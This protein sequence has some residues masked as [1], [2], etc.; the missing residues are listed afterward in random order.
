[1]TQMSITK[2]DQAMDVAKRLGFLPGYPRDYEARY[3]IG[4]FIDKICNTAEEV[5]ALYEELRSARYERWYGL[6]MIQ[7]AHDSICPPVAVK[8]PD[9]P[10]CGNSGFVYSETKL[11]DCPKCGNTGWFTMQSAEETRPPGGNPDFAPPSF[12]DYRCECGRNSDGSS[13]SGYKPCTCRHRSSNVNLP[14]QRLGSTAANVNKSAVRGQN[15]DNM[16]TSLFP[17][18]NLK[19]KSLPLTRSAAQRSPRRNRR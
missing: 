3:G 19:A 4:E 10:K 15:E 7:E 11:P 2:S 16:L 14:K 13:P 17:E 1:M 6:P 5:D 18:L 9:C 8:L 12:V